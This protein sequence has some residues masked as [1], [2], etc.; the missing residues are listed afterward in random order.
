MSKLI[1]FFIVF[2]SCFSFAQESITPL[3]PEAQPVRIAHN[4]TDQ[5]IVSPDEVLVVSRLYDTS[6]TNLA[7]SFRTIHNI[8]YVNSVPLFIPD[9][10]LT[11]FNHPVALYFKGEVISDNTP[12]SPPYGTNDA[13]RFFKKYMY[14]SLA[15]YLLTHYSSDGILLK[16][17][18]QEIII[19]K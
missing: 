11:S 13:W 1:L 17:I 7:N 15:A 5:N 19:T 14:D 9:Q 12:A 16:N 6:S 10:D 4:P 8:P 3:P 2:I 18:S